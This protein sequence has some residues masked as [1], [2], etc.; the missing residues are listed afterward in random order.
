MPRSAPPPLRRVRVVVLNW[1]GGEHVLSCLDHV[2]ATEWAGGTLEVVVVDNASTD[3]SPAAIGARFGDRVRVVPNGRNTGFP[4]NNLAMVDVVAGLAPEVHAVALVNNDAE[5]TPGWLTP[6]VAALDADPGLGAACPLLVFEPR[7]AALEVRSATFEPGAGDPRRL[8]VRIS[9]VEVAG[10]DRWDDL[11]WPEGVHDPEVGADGPFRWTDGAAH[12]RVPVPSGA[13][14]AVPVRVRVASERDVDVEVVGSDQHVVARVGSRP[15]WVATTVDAGRA[16]DVVQNA[17][18][19]VRS[20]GAGA[21]RCFGEPVGLNV[22]VGSDVFAWCGGAVLLRATY[23]RHVGPFHP[24]YFL[25]YEDVDLSWRGQARGWR[26][27]FVPDS[28]VRHRH[29]ASSGTSSVAF[30]R[31]NER[32]RLLLLVRNAP[33]PLVRRE[34]GAFTADTARAAWREVA[35]PLRR[36]RPPRPVMAWR[37]SR[38]LAS[39]VRLVPAE[40]AERRRLRRAQTVPDAHLLARLASAPDR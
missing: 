16:V 39:L 23:L 40:L 5:V 10:E 34:V 37:R 29:A 9:G 21:D 7:F 1:N 15:V 30:Q 35:G 24:P 13:S 12:L 27:R 11:L 18:S 28:V 38:A 25:Y 26:Y 8:G 19:I 3:G 17:G 2:L 20:D 14:A 4:A 33:W 32:N 6:L 36:R 31:F 22:A